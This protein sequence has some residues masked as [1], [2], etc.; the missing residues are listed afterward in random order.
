MKIT[1]KRKSEKVLFGDLDYGSV[2]EYEGEV[3]IRIH[4]TTKYAAV[5][6]D[7]GFCVDVDPDIEVFPLNVE[8]VIHDNG[9]G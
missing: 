5:Y 8:L 4:S 3:L 2:F 9:E 7:N 6:L 1:D